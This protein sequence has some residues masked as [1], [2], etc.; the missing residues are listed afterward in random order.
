MDVTASD[1]FASQNGHYQVVELLLKENADPNLQDLDGVT[2]LMFASQNGHYQV[3]EDLLKENADPNFQDQDGWTALMFGSQNGHYEVVEFLLKENA[4]L[5]LQ[6]KE[7][8]TALTHASENGHY[9]VVELL[10]KEKADPNI[11]TLGGWTALIVT[12]QNG[13]YQVVELL[14]KENA[15]P[16]LQTQCGWTASTIASQNGHIEIAHLLEKY[17]DPSSSSC[18]ELDQS[19]NQPIE[20]TSSDILIPDQQTEEPNKQLQNIKTTES[21]VEQDVLP[22]LT[23]HSSSLKQSFQNRLIKSIKEPFHTF[24]DTKKKEIRDNK[25]TILQQAQLQQH[26]S[27]LIQLPLRILRKKSKKMQTKDHVTTKNK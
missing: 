14:L 19:I 8:S 13:H 27:T 20:S 9:Q 1:M 6:T 2:A 22:H 7:N 10:L 26:H 24:K 3:V 4:D 25:S 15:D 21:V 5:N 17:I 23:I 16:S 12:S 11:Q 18:K